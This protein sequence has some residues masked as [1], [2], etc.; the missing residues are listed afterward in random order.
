MLHYN[1]WADS[2]DSMQWAIQVV[3]KETD[4]LQQ[5]VCES[6]HIQVNI[7]VEPERIRILKDVICP[8]SLVDLSPALSNKVTSSNQT[9]HRH[10][11]S[12]STKRAVRVLS[13]R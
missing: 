12:V 1:Q 13:M 9:R 5:P 7:P 10:N 6:K 11:F 2:V 3:L 4:V 8:P